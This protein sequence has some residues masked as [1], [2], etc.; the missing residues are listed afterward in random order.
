MKQLA[1]ITSCLCATFT[2]LLG[3][4][5]FN[6]TVNSAE[7]ISDP[8]MPSSH[9]WLVNADTNKPILN[10]SDYQ[11]ISRE[12]IP[13]HYSFVYLPPISLGPVNIELSGTVSAKR[14]ERVM[15][16]TLF[17]DLD[18][19]YAGNPETKI[20]QAGSYSLSANG[21]SVRFTIL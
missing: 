3:L 19:N 14:L 11:K 6:S 17:G 20:L 21:Q 13:T 7:P 18:G 4:T 1:L 15:P 12:K 5:A 9:F 10:L 2:I 16:Y 8:L